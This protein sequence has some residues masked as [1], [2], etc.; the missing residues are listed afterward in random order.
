MK[1]EVGKYYQN[2][3]GE[4]VKIIKKGNSHALC[5]SNRYKTMYCPYRQ[6]GYEYNDLCKG[7]TDKTFCSINDIFVKE[8]PSIE[9]I[10][11]VGE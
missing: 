1:I 4:I 5:K 11:C 2:I 10:L 7:C 8:V 3:M 6:V 9:G